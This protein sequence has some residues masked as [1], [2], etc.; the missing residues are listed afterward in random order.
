MSHIVDD[1]KK[2]RELLNQGPQTLNESVDES[3]DE[4]TVDED[5]VSEEDS[6]NEDE[7]LEEN[8]NEAQQ[9]EIIGYDS[10][11]GPQLD[12]A[13]KDPK[14]RRKV[15]VSAI[16]IGSRGQPVL[17]FTELDGSG[18]FMAEWD[19]QHGWHADFS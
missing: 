2:F 19:P 4:S 12:Q 14:H 5:N 8:L 15:N 10:G 18:P 11:I 1:I 13:A 9:V 3:V 6:V 17:K 16:T 7:E